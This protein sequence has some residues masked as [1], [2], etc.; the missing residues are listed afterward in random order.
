[1]YIVQYGVDNSHMCEFKDFKL[2]RDAKE[3]YEKIESKYEAK[4]CQKLVF[5]KDGFVKGKEYKL[6]KFQPGTDNTTMLDRMRE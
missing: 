4:T 3:F 1:M 5:D 6:F 2:Y